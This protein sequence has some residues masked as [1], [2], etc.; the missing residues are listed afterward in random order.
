MLS[1]RVP[2]GLP[3]RTAN[4][5]GRLARWPGAE[6]SDDDGKL[7]RTFEAQPAAEHLG[8][9]VDSAHKDF[10]RTAVE[11]SKHLPKPSFA[12]R[13]L[14]HDFETTCGRRRLFTRQIGDVRIELPQLVAGRVLADQPSPHH[15]AVRV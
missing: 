4:E 10:H 7:L 15:S 3:R 5:R 11:L 8:I 9:G 2:A 14:L 1:A 13:D 6:P 12:E